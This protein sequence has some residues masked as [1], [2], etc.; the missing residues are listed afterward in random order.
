M[1]SPLPAEMKG[2]GG[3]PAERA[4]GAFAWSLH[5]LGQK[6]HLHPTTGP[7]KAVPEP[8]RSRASSERGKK[9]LMKEATKRWQGDPG[10]QSVDSHF[11]LAFVMCKA[12]RRHPR[13]S[14]SR[15]IAKKQHLKHL[16]QVHRLTGSLSHLHSARTALPALHKAVGNSFH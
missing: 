4:S 11:P 10:C 5:P 8:P 13:L 6:R 9:K 7:R 14:S 12:I 15:T 2:E 3:L 1:P 16:R